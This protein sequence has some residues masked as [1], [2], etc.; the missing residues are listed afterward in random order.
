ML[1]KFEEYF[2]NFSQNETKYN[3]GLDGLEYF[4]E[5]GGAITGLTNTNE[6]TFQSVVRGLLKLPKSV[7]EFS[8]TD[9]IFGINLA[10]AQNKKINDTL[11]RFLRKRVTFK[12][13]NQNDINKRALRT[14]IGDAKYYD[15][16]SY[17][18]NLP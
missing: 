8:D 4:T 6:M 14:F 11:N 18:N 9:S 1:D 10:K 15:F 13:H 2:L 7:V 16:G 5:E 12:F 3:S 17:Q